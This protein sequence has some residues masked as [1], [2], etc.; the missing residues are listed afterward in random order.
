MSS[1]GLIY[2]GTYRKLIAQKI[3][4]ENEDSI[5]TIEA[6]YLP[7]DK[8]TNL[9]RWLI[10]FSQEMDISNQTHLS[11]K[12][13][14]VSDLKYFEEIARTNTN[15]TSLVSTLEVTH[16][17]IENDI[18]ASFLSENE[19]I[20]NE[21]VPV[22]RRALEASISK[23]FNKETNTPIYT[24]LIST[25]FTHGTKTKEKGTRSHAD[26]KVSRR[27]NSQYPK[28]TPFISSA[29]TSYSLKN[30]SNTSR[31]ILGSGFDIDF[32]YNNSTNLFGYKVNHLISPKISYNYRQKKSQSHIPIFDSTDKFDNIV[33][34][35]DITSGKRYNGLDRISNANDITLSLESSYRDINGFEDEKK[36]DLL[37]LKAAQSYYGDKEVVSDKLN[38]N[39]ESRKSYSDIALSI[40]LSVENFSFSSAGQFNPNKSKFLQTE[41]IF[42]YSPSNRK[43]I[44]LSLLDE[45]KKQTNKIHGSFPLSDSIHFFGGK[46]KTTSKITS[47]ESESETTGL[48]YESCCWA[49]RVAHF[50]E[51][52]SSGGYNYSTGME[53]V[54]KGLGSTSTPLKGKIESKI[55]EYSAEL[56]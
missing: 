8:L 40:D 44:A 4:P 16:N 24:K 12:F 10:N 39:Y 7:K 3:S 34:F 15:E 53:L 37:N 25:K 21:G 28:I 51:D 48:T 38:T 22:Y 35:K 20:V 26:I 27:L 5:L 11:V 23:N 54:F 1:R 9:K 43:F 6:K 2:E 19:Q 41:N 18:N 46:D 36:K 52:N 45:E 17:D 30:N 50:K 32:S 14:R 29:I 56:R 13:H 55:P 47:E 49:L 31:I 42:S 33:T